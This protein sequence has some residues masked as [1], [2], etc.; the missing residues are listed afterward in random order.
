MIDIPHIQA[1][2]G[3]HIVHPIKPAPPVVVFYVNI[4]ST[5]FSR[6]IEIHVAR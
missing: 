5:K 1:I 2:K 4:L 3:P 6:R